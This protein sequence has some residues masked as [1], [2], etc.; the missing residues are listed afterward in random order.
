MRLDDTSNI[1]ITGCLFPLINLIWLVAGLFLLV[2]GGE[3]L[4]RGASALARLFRVSPLVIGL[5]VV[6]F[7]TSAPELATCIG[8]AL[9]GKA[10]LAIGNV[11]GSN[12]ANVL[13]ILGV[14]ALI[15]PLNVQSRLVR[16]DVP[17]MIIVSV[18]V[19]AMSWDG[20]ISRL[21]GCL[22]FLGIIVYTGWL[23]RESRKE[24]TDVVVEFAREFDPA[25]AKRP[26]T[27]YAVLKQMA[28]ILVG[29]ILLVLGANWLV[30]GA[31]SLAR[32][33]RISD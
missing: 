17:L 30:D 24:P 23:I 6:A 13:L 32:A 4:V 28:S 19:W 8:A 2:V 33:W 14:A 26:L 10:D 20:N 27:K 31:S 22:L 9:T 25:L 5:T 21:D 29:L 11:V 12:I 7:G 3:A 16:L 15:T 1:T 18:V